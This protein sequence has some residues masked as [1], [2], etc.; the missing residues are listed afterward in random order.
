MHL[1]KTASLCAVLALVASA[2]LSETWYPAGGWKDTDD[3]V[4]SP[5]AKKGGVLRFD[6]SSAPNSF[7]A[8]IDTS[9]YVQMMF[10][11][12]YP[13][14]IATDTETLDFVPSLAAKWSVS[15]DE[16]AF[17][18]V[19]D[20]RARWSD[21]V[22][23]TA[24]DVAWTYD[25]VMDEKSDSGFWKLVLGKFEKAEVLDADSP[26]P[27]TVRF[28]KRRDKDGKVQ[29]DWRDV[30]HCGMFYILPKHHF[31]DQEFNKF[32]FVG[33]PV[34]G[35]YCIARTEEQ[36]QTVYERVKDWW[37]RDFPSCRYT[38]N[39][40]R[41]VMRYYSGKENAFHAF[42]KGVIDVYP[43]YSA[44]IMATETSGPKFEHNWILK[45]RVSNHEPIGFQG[46]AMNMRRPPFDDVRVR[47]AMSMLI[48]RERLNHEMMYDEYF[49]QRSYFGDLYDSEHEG[50]ETCTNHV[51]CTNPLY[52]FDFDKASALLAEAGY[53]RNEKT[54]ILE[55]DGVPFRFTFLS[56]DG[57][58]AY[59]TRFV[60]CLKRLGIEMTID[61][62]DFASWMRDM[63]EFNFDMTWASYSS[64]IFRTP[65][66]TW[67]SAEADRKH[68]NNQVGFKS[69]EVDRLIEAE[70]TMKTF[71]EREAAYREIDRLA[72]EQCP[73]AFLWN[74]AAKRLLYWNKFG[75]P[76]T[77]LGRYNNEADVLTYWWYDFDRA[78][79]LDEA[80]EKGKYLPSVPEKVDYDTV[81][82][83][84][85]K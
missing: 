73:Y 43:V 84:R 25:L 80:I 8:Y 9:S 82:E 54:G 48:D 16:T 22:P 28:V 59:L 34:C 58:A 85:R 64:S 31:E 62:K 49:L 30:T 67:S 61:N 70:K 46:F 72:S 69:P 83:G 50:W 60:D 20:E 17:T 52:L 29:H 68:G 24:N 36:V 55:K 33:A 3:P 41:I 45:R 44:R 40:D 13:M 79:E 51:H 37:R 5:R 32:D 26:R 78:E 65:E 23:V 71:A 76:D 6:G 1:P 14:L 39:F 47:K 10:S 81:M 18:F 2:G 42:K 38:C 57:H 27:L 19:I 12:M 4:A 74:I 53:R 75:M 15:D 77:V 56:R 7:N 66:I 21:G 35:P 63:D 11:L